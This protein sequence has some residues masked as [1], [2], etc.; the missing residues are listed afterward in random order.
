ME[1]DGGGLVLQWT[2]KGWQWWLWFDPSYMIISENWIYIIIVKFNVI[3]CVCHVIVDFLFRV[4]THTFLNKAA[5]TENCFALPIY[6]PFVFLFFT[7]RNVILFFMFRRTSRIH[8]FIGVT[9]P[10]PTWPWLYLQLLVLLQGL[11]TVF[12]HQCL[13][14][15]WGDREACNRLPCMQRQPRV[16][17]GFFIHW[18][19]GYANHCKLCVSWKSVLKVYRY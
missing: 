14:Y 4:K 18:G 16:A 10:W 13:V 6:L 12:E 11:F 17:A 1:N 8:C 15:W 7:V 2:S 19:T 3:P 9:S 5:I